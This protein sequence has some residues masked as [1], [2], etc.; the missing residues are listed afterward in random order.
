[1]LKNNLADIQKMLARWKEKLAY[2]SI[3]EQTGAAVNELKSELDRMLDSWREKVEFPVDS[4]Y[5]DLETA[6][7]ELQNASERVASSI[8]NIKY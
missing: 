4:I 5:Q 1:M 2:V 3:P 8:N 6:K 7:K